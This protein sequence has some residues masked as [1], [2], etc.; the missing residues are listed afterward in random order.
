MLQILP[1]APQ[2]ALIF[3]RL[4]RAWIEEYFTV[5][6][7]DELVLTQPE[8]YILEPGGEI[9]F[10]QLDGHIIGCCALLKLEPGMMEFT[11]LGVDPAA[12]GA[13]VARALLQHCIERARECGAHT[14]R[15]FTNSRLIPACTLYRSAGFE[16]RMMSDAQ[17]SRYVRGDVMFDYPLKEIT[18]VPA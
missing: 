10:A 15:I 12:R 4:N 1:Y 8:K 17:R 7:L 3:N 2:H 16:E 18:S 5:E 9:W 13:G 11:K 14:L 6:P